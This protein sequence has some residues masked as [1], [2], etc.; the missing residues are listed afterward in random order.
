MGQD[1]AVTSIAVW[2]TGGGGPQRHRL[3]PDYL[4]PHTVAPPATSGTAVSSFVKEQAISQ[5]C[6]WRSLTG[7]GAYKTRVTA[8]LHGTDFAYF[9]RLVF[10]LFLY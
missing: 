7:V 4:S 1:A 6:V 2:V 8:W 10:S 9:F 3:P 5:E